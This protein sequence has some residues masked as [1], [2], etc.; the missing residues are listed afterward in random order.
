MPRAA[1][2][3]DFL[4]HNAL[5]ESRAIGCHECS[6]FV[7]RLAAGRR[8]KLKGVVVPINALVKDMPYM[9]HIPVV[10]RNICSDVAWVQI[11]QLLWVIAVSGRSRR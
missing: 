11:A 4:G 7:N 5:F 3:G 1:G 2:L 10:K 6:I 8:M 9:F